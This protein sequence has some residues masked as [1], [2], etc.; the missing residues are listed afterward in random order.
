MVAFTKFNS[1]TSACLTKKHDFSADTF[2]VMLTDT[3]PVA[4]NA[5]T[6]DITQIGTTGGYTTGGYATTVG[7]SNVSGQEQVTLTSVTVTASGATMGNWRYPVLVNATAG[8]LVGWADSGGEISLA[9]G[10]TE[11]IS[12]ASPALTLG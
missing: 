12:F 3:A 5:V 8:L 11:T 4:T 1:F 6:T 10:A 2:K 9:S 7:L